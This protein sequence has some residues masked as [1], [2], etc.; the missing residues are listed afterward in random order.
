MGIALGLGVVVVGWVIYTFNRL[1]RTPSAEQQ[2]VV[3]TSTCSSNDG[4]THPEMSWRLCKAMPAMSAARSR[5]WSQRAGEPSRR[6][7][8][9][10]A[11]RLAKRTHSAVELRRVV[12]VPSIS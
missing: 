11:T 10:P 6:R 5:P 1:I 8:S 2:R 12:A 4:T 3:P 9:G 7:N